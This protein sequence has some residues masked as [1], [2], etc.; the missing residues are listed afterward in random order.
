MLDKETSTHRGRAQARQT[1]SALFVS[2]LPGLEQQRPT[3]A[4]F[5]LLLLIEQ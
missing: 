1:T 5:P 3:R 2:Y 4:A